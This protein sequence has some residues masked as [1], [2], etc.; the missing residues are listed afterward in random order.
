[1]N[2]YSDDYC[3]LYDIRHY[4]SYHTFKKTETLYDIQKRISSYVGFPIEVMGDFGYDGGKRFDTE[5]NEIYNIVKTYKS[6]KKP[7]NTGTLN[8]SEIQ[9]KGSIYDSDIIRKRYVYIYINIEKDKNVK[10]LN[11]A[12]LK[13]DKEVIK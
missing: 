4:R 10:N 7:N 8:Y 3:S 9:I 5:S 2:K 13:K 6:P 11:D 1:M 12:I